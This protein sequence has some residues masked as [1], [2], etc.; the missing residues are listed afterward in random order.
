MAWEGRYFCLD[1]RP[2]DLSHILFFMQTFARH[3]TSNAQRCGLSPE[4][5]LLLV[6][7]GFDHHTS[8]GCRAF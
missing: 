4:T 3:S 5:K 6:S 8:S 2:G 7:V 1:R